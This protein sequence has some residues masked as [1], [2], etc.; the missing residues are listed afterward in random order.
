MNS[1]FLN[2][3]SQIENPEEGL[4]FLSENTEGKI[5]FSTSFGIEDQVISHG[6]FG[7]KLKNIE[8]FTLDTG[9]LFPETYAVWDKTLLQYNQPIRVY[10]PDTD[11][12]ETYVNKNG[13][14]GFY[15]SVELRKECCHIRKVIP[16]QK[17]VKGAKVWITGL[18]AQQSD[19]RNN[20]EIIQW[21]EQYQLYK[22]NPLLHWSTDDVVHYLKRNGVPYNTLH[23][24]NF[25]SIGCAP[26]T[27][28]VKKGEDFRAGRWWWED[29]SKKE[30]GLHQ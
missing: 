16:L 6:V 5:V 15:N 1:N 24:Q 28:A 9:R 22:Y 18:R 27:R 26:C 3:L 11:E 19:N 30:C 23:D 7:Q 25:I 14:N 2:Q 10:Y 20:L 12:L 17:A 29:Q 13:I 4:R 8:A 21:D